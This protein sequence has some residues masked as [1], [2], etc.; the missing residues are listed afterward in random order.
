[1]RYIGARASDWHSDNPNVRAS[2]WFGAFVGVVVMYFVVAAIVGS[3]MNGN[4][5]PFLS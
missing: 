4:G 5:S 3:L 2:L 1:M